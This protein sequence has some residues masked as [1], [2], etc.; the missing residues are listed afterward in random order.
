ML[1]QIVLIEG[2]A[3]FDGSAVFHFSGLNACI[4]SHS[5]SFHGGQG[6]LR[7]EQQ[8][9]SWSDSVPSA[10]QLSY[11]VSHSLY[12]LPDVKQTDVSRHAF[13]INIHIFIII[14]RVRT[15]RKYCFCSY[16]RENIL[17]YSRHT[18][19]NLL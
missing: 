2:I 15:T 8:R 7:N 12:H 14:F 16:N 13:P 6:K 1:L 3:A 11:S 17:L 10:A 5:L 19:T 9:S 4:R 18:E